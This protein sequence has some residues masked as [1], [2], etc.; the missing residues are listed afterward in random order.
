M[1]QRTFLSFVCNRAES[2]PIT[3]FRFSPQA[4]TPSTSV[5]T[6]TKTLCSIRC[7]LSVSGLGYPIKI[8]GNCW[9]TCGSPAD[10]TSSFSAA[11][12]AGIGRFA[13]WKPWIYLYTSTLWGEDQNEKENIWPLIF[14]VLVTGNNKFRKR[15]VCLHLCFDACLGNNNKFIFIYLP[16]RWW[17]CFLIKRIMC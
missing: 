17:W 3:S 16:E 7:N 11:W 6:F 13:H 1:C 2:Q 10:K 4:A 14:V 12:V 9:L 8:E 15:Y 5:D